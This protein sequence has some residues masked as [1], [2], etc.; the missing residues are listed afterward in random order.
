MNTKREFVS[1]DGALYHHKNFAGTAWAC[2]KKNVYSREG[3]DWSCFASCCKG[4]IRFVEHTSVS[5]CGTVELRVFDEGTAPVTKG[6][7][8]A[9]NSAVIVVHVER[10]CETAPK[11][12]ASGVLNSVA[13][14]RIQ[15]MMLK[16]SN[17][18]THLLMQI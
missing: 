16:Q 14:E 13:I 12:M 7:S 10:P 2:H 4:P 1:T 6:L 3:F 15:K 9:E 5:T 17:G 11:L 18:W 8:R